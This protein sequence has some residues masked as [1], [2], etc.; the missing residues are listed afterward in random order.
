[1][2]REEKISEV[3]RARIKRNQ[4]RT[5]K[6]KERTR[7]TR[8]TTLIGQRLCQRGERFHSGLV[9]IAKNLISVPP[10]RD[11]RRARPVPVSPG[12]CG[13]INE[14]LL[15]LPESSNFLGKQSITLYAY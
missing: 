13:K 2:R 15:G 3:A 12:N 5:E 10:K 6:G 11:E 4:V 9:P 7:L 8:A 14:A 1:M